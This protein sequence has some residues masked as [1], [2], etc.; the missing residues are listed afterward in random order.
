MVY[1]AGGC[2]QGKGWTAGRTG[3]DRMA[4][5]FMTGVESGQGSEKIKSMIYKD[6]SRLGRLRGA[7]LLE[8]GTAFNV[9]YVAFE[10]LVGQSR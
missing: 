4:L 7:W 10:A 2:A 8:K 1:C 5:T 3:N 6:Y 9:G